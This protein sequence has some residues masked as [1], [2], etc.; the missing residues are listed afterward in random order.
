METRGQ[1]QTHCHHIEIQEANKEINDNDNDN[2]D[3]DK[4]KDIILSPPTHKLSKHSMDTL[5]VCSG[6]TLCTQN[7]MDATDDNSSHSPNHS[8]SCSCANHHHQTSSC[9][10]SCDSSCLSNVSLTNSSLSPST[11]KSRSM[12]LCMSESSP[13][14]NTRDMREINTSNRNISINGDVLDQNLTVLRLSNSETMDTKDVYVMANESSITSNNKNNSKHITTKNDNK[15]PKQKQ[16]KN[17]QYQ[18]TLAV[19]KWSAEEMESADEYDSEA[20]TQTDE[21][22]II[23]RV[24]A[25]CV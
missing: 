11:A 22:V 6:D 4:S 13:I 18:Q 24:L 9:T 12:A 17:G 1:T 5:S 19:P 23:K 8:Q 20:H 2:D 10:H 25:K 21:D 3:K 7:I 15:S 16:N 14:S